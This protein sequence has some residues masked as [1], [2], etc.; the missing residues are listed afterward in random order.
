MSE[1]DGKQSATLQP[2]PTNDREAWKAY[3]KAQG[4]PWRTEP[5]IDGERQKYLA[6]RRSIIPNTEQGI[7]PFKS[8][9]LTRADVEWLLA[10][11]ENGRGPVDWSDESQR[12]RQG[13]DLRGADLRRANLSGLPM[14][15]L[16]AGLPWY[17]KNFHT[18]EQL[19]YTGVCLERADLR[20]THLEGATLRGAHLEHANLREA[21]LEEADLSRAHLEGAN[22][23]EAH[24]NGTKFIRTHLEWADLPDARE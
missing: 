17:K 3:W 22:L 2:P 24:L 6:E 12:R 14:A 16:C 5:E 9:K 13:L 15:C 8:I 1:Q 10:T 20:E 11:H 19:D 23:R 7:Y 4:Q 21:F 18:S